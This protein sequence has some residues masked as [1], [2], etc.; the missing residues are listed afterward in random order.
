[1]R[2]LLAW[3]L[4][5]AGYDVDAAPDGADLCNRLARHLL[6][7]DSRPVDLVISD[8]RMPGYSGLD[9]IKGLRNVDRLPPTILITAFGDEENHRQ[10]EEIGVLLLDKPFEIDELLARVRE[11]LGS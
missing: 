9:V 6:H 11:V 7:T 8:I 1:M 2:E 5:D 3:A 10:A 4:L